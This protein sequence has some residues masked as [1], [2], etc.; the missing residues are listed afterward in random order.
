MGAGKSHWLYDP[1]VESVVAREGLAA[2]V[3]DD[4]AHHLRRQ[5]AGK[6]HP[7]GGA[8]GVVLDTNEPNRFPGPWLGEPAVVCALHVFSI[9]WAVRKLERA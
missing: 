7:G 4:A 8:A 2:A 5:L 9:G 1:E 3:A 6:P